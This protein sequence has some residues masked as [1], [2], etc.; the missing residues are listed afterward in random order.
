[1]KRISADLVHAPAMRFVAARMK[2]RSSAFTNPA[3]ARWMH[4]SRGADRLVDDLYSAW[5]SGACS[6]PSATR[7]AL[8]GGT[9][10]RLAAAD[11]VL[12]ERRDDEPP[13]S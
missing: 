1:L 7:A 2:L 5:R 11:R 6:C 10:A 4:A 8:R 9:A 3:A 12:G 13:Y